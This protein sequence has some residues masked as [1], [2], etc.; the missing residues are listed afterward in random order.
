MPI[1]AEAVL[2]PAVL[3]VVLGDGERVEHGVGGFL[4]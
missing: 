1:H 2:A 3:G 4:E